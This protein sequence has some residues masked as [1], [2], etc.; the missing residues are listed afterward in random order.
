MWSLTH[1][2]WAQRMIFR[3]TMFERLDDAW[4]RNRACHE[5]D[6]N[7]FESFRWQTLR[8]EASPETMPVARD[9]REAGDSVVADEV[10]DL[11]A[12]DVRGAVIASAGAGVKSRVSSTGPRFGQT[13][14]KVLRVGAHVERSNR[15]AQIFH[16]AF[17][18]S[19]RSRNHA[20]CSAPRMVV[21]G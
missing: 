13:R 18:F 12:L 5:S 6:A 14:G 3:K 7:R 9:G 15:V 20:F 21:G 17:D 4:R 8:G 10:V 16:V 11:T 19:N 2:H 1:K